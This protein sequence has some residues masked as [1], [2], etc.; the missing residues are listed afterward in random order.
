MIWYFQRLA[1]K[2]KQPWMGKDPRWFIHLRHD[3]TPCPP[4][5]SIRPRPWLLISVPE[6]EHHGL[7]GRPNVLRSLLNAEQSPLWDFSECVRYFFSK[8]SHFVWP[9]LGH[10]ILKV[11][12][13]TCFILS[14]IVLLYFIHFLS[15]PYKLVYSS[16]PTFAH[17]EWASV[18]Q[19]VDRI[20]F[21]FLHGVLE[22]IP[23][24]QADP[25]ELNLK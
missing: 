3:P 9:R 7:Q 2:R 15:S 10:S 6:G 18:Y 17:S 4:W 16:P 12:V 24:G 19:L 13:E 21:F 8:S 23:L 25:L 22:L 14:C 20:L 5:L 1:R 11:N